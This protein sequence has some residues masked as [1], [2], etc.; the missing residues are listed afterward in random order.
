MTRSFR[1]AVVA[2]HPIQHFRPQY[3]SWAKLPDVD[4]T[5]FFASDHG[6]SAYRDPGFGRDVKWDGQLDFPHEFLDDAA[7][8]PVTHRIDAPD[9][10]ARLSH[11]SP[12]VVVAYGYSQKVQRRAVRWARSARVPVLMTSDSELRASRTWPVRATKAVVVPW[13]L[14]DVTFFLTVGDANEAYYRHYGVSDDR[15]VR[16][17]FPID[18]RHYDSIMA[19]RQCV[20]DRLR[21]ELGLPADHKVVL[22]V[23]KLVP[24]KR[25]ADLVRFS[26]ALQQH[27]DN[28]TVVIAGTG[29]ED[30]A[31]RALAARTGTGGVMFAGFVSPERLAEYYCAADVYVHCS[32]DEPHSLAITEAVYTGLPVVV[33]DRCGSHGPTD[34]VQPGVNGFVYRCGDVQDLSQRI[35]HILDDGD[36]HAHLSRASMR[37]GAAHQALAHGQGLL[38][39]LTRVQGAIDAGFRRSIRASITAVAAA[40]RR[41]WREAPQRARSN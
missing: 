1:V 28:V 23:G 10:G 35:M 38:H 6:V 41:R 9:L 4:L 15:F 8:K 5:V 32:A 24:R 17:S 2:S 40:G 19:R 31:L 33:S 37:I 20:R 34:D 18:V 7:G 12:D 14:K 25:H 16:C 22:T 39:A 26:N 13:L 11:F 3:S 36:L 30:D 21:A 27:R 29:Q